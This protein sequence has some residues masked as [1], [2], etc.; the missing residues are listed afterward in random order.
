[1]MERFLE[2]CETGNLD[3]LKKLD[4]AQIDIH[5]RKE[6]AF[7][8]ACR[9]GYID[10]VKYLIWLGENGHGLINIHTL[11]NQAFRNACYEGHVD[12]AEYLVNLGPAYGQI[13]MNA[14]C[15]TVFYAA[16]LREQ[17]NVVKLLL[18][19]KNSYGQSDLGRIF[20]LSSLQI[21]RIF[22]K[23]DPDY[24]WSKVDGYLVYIHQLKDITENLLILHAA[25]VNSDIFDS[26]VLSIVMDYL[27]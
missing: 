2:C 17:T 14:D 24:D 4:Y 11:C 19:I 20:S 8:M 10:V 27:L 23:N 22:V 1:M 25:T 12:I 21:K 26:N 16:C 15:G 13:C 7:R 9:H 6:Q 3:E 5:D 18:S